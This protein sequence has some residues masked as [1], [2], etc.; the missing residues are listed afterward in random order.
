MDRKIEKGRWNKKRVWTIAGITALVLLIASSIY[1]TS[2]KSKLNV[3]VERITVSEVKKDAFQE[4]IPVNGVVLPQTT[5]Y[6][7][8][9]EGGRV[10]EKYVDDGAFVKKGATHTSSFKHRP[11]AEPC[12]PADL[13]LQPAYP[14]ADRQ[15]CRTTKHD[16]EA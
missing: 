8:A 12:E 15:K 5:I 11:R 3:D 10:E 14:N 6:L 2:G 7:D 13:C 4:T 16:N 1:F 9:V